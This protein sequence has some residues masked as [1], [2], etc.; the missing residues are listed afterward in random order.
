M[1]DQ[2]DVVV[3]HM[4]LAPASGLLILLLVGLLAAIVAA[5]VVILVVSRKKNPPSNPNLIPCPDSG[6]HVSRL[7]KSCPQCGRPLSREGEK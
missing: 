6:R 2:G 7:A 3:E 5:V 1:V 4:T